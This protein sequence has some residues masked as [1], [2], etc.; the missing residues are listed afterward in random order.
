M[1]N[2]PMTQSLGEWA[3]GGLLGQNSVTFTNAPVSTWT[4]YANNLKVPYATGG[5]ITS[6]DYNT[7][8]TNWL[9][10]PSSTAVPNNEIIWPPLPRIPIADNLELVQELLARIRQLEEALAAKDKMMA[11]PEIEDEQP[12]PSRKFRLN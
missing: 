6:P 2:M 4:T 1:S 12:R 8:E 5:M 10:N 11:L 3:T 9:Y 7:V